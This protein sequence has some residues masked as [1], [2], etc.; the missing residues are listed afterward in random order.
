MIFLFVDFD[1][2][3]GKVP[4][5]SCI[6]SSFPCI[7]VHSCCR[8]I[9]SVANVVEEETSSANGCPKRCRKRWWDCRNCSQKRSSK[10]LFSKRLSNRIV[11]C[12]SMRR[13]VR[14]DSSWIPKAKRIRWIPK[15][16]S[17]KLLS[18]RNGCYRYNRILH[19]CSVSERNGQDA[20]EILFPN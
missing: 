13:Q 5:F 4:A 14:F 11:Y 1:L 17:P 7:L 15:R 2:S 18:V 19:R 16:V 12:R 8:Y 10:R 9:S 20:R 3:F 6:S